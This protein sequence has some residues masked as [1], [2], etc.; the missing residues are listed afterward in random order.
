MRRQGP[1]RFVPGKVVEFGLTVAFVYHLANGIRHLVWDSGHGL[2]V[3]SAN[4][5]SVTV[6]AFSAAATLAIWFI[7]YRTGAL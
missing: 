5:S 7:A 6:F 1:A 2:D 3:K 4:A